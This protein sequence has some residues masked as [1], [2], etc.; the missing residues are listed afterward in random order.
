MADYAACGTQEQALA[1]QDTD[2]DTEMEDNGENIGESKD[3]GESS[4]EDLDGDLGPFPDYDDENVLSAAE[5]AFDRAFQ[6]R[7][8]NAANGPA[9]ARAAHEAMQASSHDGLAGSR[10]AQLQRAADE[11]RAGSGRGDGGHQQ[12]AGPYVNGPLNNGAQINAAALQG[13]TASGISALAQVGN[14]ASTQYRQTM[15]ALA[16]QHAMNALHTPISTP[17]QTRY[18]RAAG[19]HD[20]AHTNGTASDSVMMQAGTV[21]ASRVSHQAGAG[22][23]QT[24]AAKPAPVQATAKPTRIIR[25]PMKQTGTPLAPGKKPRRT[26]PPRTIKPLYMDSSSGDESAESDADSS[27]DYVQKDE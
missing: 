18:E 3:E 8:A 13:T 2:G 25:L 14:A 19:P 7:Q 11:A 6:P 27:G 26:K 21:Q 10:W 5:I 1:Y 16:Q 15:T 20:F 17:A 4:E 24:G 22:T 23:K 9:Q 12:G